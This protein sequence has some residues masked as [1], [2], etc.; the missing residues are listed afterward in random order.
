MEM[1]LKLSNIVK[2]L[3]L[4][5][6][7]ASI[8][9]NKYWV[10]FTDKSESI[11]Y[12][13]D[14]SFMSDESLN[15]RKFQQILI[16]EKDYPLS[17]DYIH[18]INNIG[19][20]ICQSSRWLNA[21]TVYVQDSHDLQTLK[22]LDF[23]KHIQK[24]KKLTVTT[25]VE[26]EMS[27]YPITEGYYGPSFGQIAQINGHQVHAQGYYGA[28]CTIAVIDAS[29]HKV[30]QLPI[31]DSLWVNNQ[32]IDTW[33]FVLNQE[34]DYDI[35]TIGYHG[36]MVLSCMGGYMTDSL[37]GTAPKANYL[38]YR[39]EDTS[40][41]SLSEEDFWVAAAERADMQ[42]A[43]IIN[44]SLGYSNMDDSLTSHTYNDM[45]GNSTIITIAADIAASKGILVVNSAGNSG[46]NDWYYITAPA[47]GDSVLAVGAIGA[48][49][50]ITSFSSRGPSADGRLKPNVVAQG[51]YTTVANLDGGITYANGTSFSAPIISG[52]AASVWSAIP[53]LTNMDLFHLIQESGHLYPYGDNAYGN[54]IPDFSRI[55]ELLSITD[56]KQP[57]ISI[58][59][60]PFV[61]TFTI[62][63]PEQKMEKVDILIYNSLGQK[64][65]SFNEHLSHKLTIQIPEVLPSGTYFIQITRGTKTFY[66]RLVK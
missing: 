32:I 30:N 28:G 2:I 59:P 15:K 29:F 60:N 1:N 21:V 18:S 65:L 11:Q 49:S 53:Y 48:D 43:N 33:D 14:Y 38:L 42:G 50:L 44:T 12:Y 20:T 26:Y 22:S 40:S 45:D 10:F 34:L 35:D 55:L 56:G 16:D 51:L 3:C 25:P 24:V 19:F 63:F 39:T 61:N 36:T 54:G 7:F 41:E 27:L 64:V 5:I 23:V 47:D 52:M 46:S 62:L 58:Y 37:I 17:A 31:F 8:A 66:R 57:N 6:P 9:Q 13:E 4:L